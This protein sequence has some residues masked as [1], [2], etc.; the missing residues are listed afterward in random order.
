MTLRLYNITYNAFTVTVKKCSGL[1]LV[2]F[3]AA[4]SLHCF[5]FF[6]FNGHSAETQDYSR[7]KRAERKESSD[8]LKINLTRVHT[9]IFN[10]RALFM[11]VILQSV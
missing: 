3:E 10:H 1:S 6:T 2:S 4:F 8:N 11:L 9:D 7:T 5:S